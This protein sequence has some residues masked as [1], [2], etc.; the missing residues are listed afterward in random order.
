MR[1]PRLWQLPANRARADID[2][3]QSPLRLGVRRRTL[4][5]AQ[6]RLAG[7]PFSCIAFRVDATVLE[8]LEVITARRRVE[9]P[10]KSIGRSI[11]RSA[12]LRARWRRPLVGKEDGTPVRSV[13]AVLSQLI[14]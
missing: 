6:V 9:R 11:F 4:R 14:D 3:P 2:G 10:R 1:G 5:S 7:L 13:P 8:R 12:D